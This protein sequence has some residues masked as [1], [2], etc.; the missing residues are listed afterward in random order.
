MNRLVLIIF[1]WILV[2]PMV[3]ASD[4]IGINSSDPVPAK[5]ELIT[6]TI[7]KSVI[8]FTVDGFFKN[9]VETTRGVS[10]VIGLDDGTPIL[11]KNAPDLSK[12][13]ASLIIPDQAYMEVKIISSAFTEYTDI[14]IAPSKGNFTRD[15]DPATVPFEYGKVYERDSFYPG[16]LAELRSPYILRDHRGQTVVVYPFQYNPVSKVLRVYHIIEIEVYQVNNQGL[17]TFDRD[18]EPVSINKEFK[19]IYTRHFLNATDARYDPVDDYGNM[20]IICYTDFMDEMEPFVDWKVKTGMP[21]E[22]VDVATIGGSSAIKTYVENYYN[23]NGLTFL[24]LVG[25]ASQIPSRSYNG[26]TASDNSYGYITGDDSYPEL[27]VGRF[28][29]EIPDQV[30]TQVQRT[31]NYESDPIATSDW[32]TKSIGVASSQGPGDDDEMDYEHIR[33]MQTDLF[34]YGYTYGAELFDG[35]QGGNDAPGNPTPAM[36]GDEVDAGASVILYTGHGSSTSW[37]SSGFSNNNV[38]TLTNAGMLPFIWSVACVNGAFVGTT[39][40]AEAWLRATNDDG[41]PTGAIAVLMSTVSQSWDPPMEGQDEM[42]DILV[43]SYSENIKRTYGGISMN[44]CMQ[45]NDTYG[46]AGSHETDAWTCFGDPSLVVRTAFPLGMTVAHDPTLLIG[47]TQFTV[48]SDAE[49]GLV[50]LSMENEV[51]GTGVIESGIAIVEI[52]PVLEPGVLTIVITAY[53]YIPY[54]AEIDIIPA[55]GPYI[56]INSYEIDDSMAN[57]NNQL[58]YG[59]SV[60]LSLG[61]KN[62]GTDDAIN[63]SVTISSNDPYVIILDDYEAYDTVAS[64]EV[65]IIDNGFAIEVAEDVPDNHLIFFN[66]ETT[67]NS[68]ETWSSNFSVPAHAPVL[69]FTNFEIVDPEGNNNGRLDPGETAEIII[70]IANTG[71]SEAIDVMG[72]LSSDDVYITFETDTMGYGM[73]A[74]GDTTVQSFVVVADPTT[75]PG[76]EVSFD[77]EITAASTING[78]GSFSAIVGQIPVLILDLDGNHNSGIIIQSI[79]DNFGMAYDHFNGFPENMNLYSSVFVCLGVYSNNHVLTNDEGQFLA[80]YLNSGGNLYM[81]GA[82]TWAYNSATPVHGMFNINGV[83]DGS[84]NMGLLAGQ[85]GTFTENMAFNYTGDNN[86]MDHIEPISPAF[87]IFENT[88]PQYGCAVAYD[89]GSYR[90][91]GTS[92]EFGG[93]ADGASP[94]TKEDL[95]LKILEFFGI[96]QVPLGIVQGVVTDVETGQLIEDAQIFVGS[97]RSYTDVE[98]FFSG[99]FPSG[100]NTICC[101]APGYEAMCET[102]TIYEDSTVTF[103]FSL[104]YLLPPTDIHVELDENVVTLTWS[105]NEI[106]PFQH[107]CVYRRKNAEAFSLINTTTEME[108]ADTLSVAGLYSYYVTGMY[109]YNSES[110]PSDIVTIEYTSTGINPVSKENTIT[111]LGTNFPNP[112]TYE[113]ILRYSV[114]DDI[115]VL[116]EIYNLNGQ[117]VRTLVDQKVLAGDH[118]VTW[119][120]MDD[121]GKAVPEGLYIYKMIAGNYHRTRKMVLLF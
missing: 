114:K 92:F 53:N 25:D 117:K 51:L 116:I 118:E 24:L 40:F 11:E 109:S 37:S 120:C 99:H 102:I 115:D 23:D 41:D 49:G 65:K 100:E 20:L 72:V 69:E 73:M 44:G 95:F 45:M 88:T 32:F 21:T 67:G 35:S 38:N 3:L 106:R 28:S 46:T 77:L 61:I 12:L 17:N 22:I 58:D 2:I 1:T 82:D 78:E 59:E 66:V 54:T 39:C 63:V 30:I 6:S 27:F 10:F 85:T 110:L 34:G 79:L 74:A 84:G 97:Y 103:N 26:V 9:E 33:N 113:T 76:Y 47:T 86:Y 7:E 87:S 29:A 4:W 104:T 52:E 56:V 94:S 108:Y 42:V 96:G 15:I 75:P 8:T 62:V 57:D 43:E 14:E 18:E 50:A 71:S 90:T 19:N 112:F 83:E 98:G 5:A 105:F 13:T 101:S 48:N 91:I 31:I 89:A 107:F 80:N 36:V 121:Y 64:E 81:E 16:K 119:R 60:L 111:R 68:R 93:L 70:S 55:D